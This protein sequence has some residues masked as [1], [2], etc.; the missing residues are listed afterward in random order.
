MKEYLPII[1]IAVLVLIF[2][3][4]FVLNKRTP[5]PEGS[6]EIIDEASCSACN[7]HACSHHK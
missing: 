3:I 4:T 5:L 6:V 2:V 1:I 7:N